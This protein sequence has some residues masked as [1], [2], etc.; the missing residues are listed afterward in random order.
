MP[1][2]K[3]APP[4]SLD[5][6][7]WV[8]GAYCL[9][10]GAMAFVAPHAWGRVMNA[11]LPQVRGAEGA[12]LMASG[13]ALI[14]AAADALRPALGTATHVLA[15]AVLCARAWEIRIVDNGFNLGIAANLVLG[16]GVALAPLA[17]RV[18][19]GSESARHDWLSMVAAALLIAGSVV[20]TPAHVPAEYRPFL[21]WYRA[22]FL[23]AGACLAAAEIRG[24][25]S[26]ALYRAAHL[27]AGATMVAWLVPSIWL[28][29]WVGFAFWFSLGL[30]V[31]LVPW[32]GP[33]LARRDKATLRSRLTLSMA[34]LS[35]IPLI[36]IATLFALRLEQSAAEQAFRLQESIALA[37]SH[38]VEDFVSLHEAAASGLAAEPGLLRLPPSQQQAMMDRVNR[39]FPQATTFSLG[40]AAGRNVAKSRGLPLLSYADQPQ[41]LNVRRTNQPYVTVVHG[42]LL[43]G[44]YIT[45]TVPIRDRD[46]KFEGIVQTGIETTRLANLVE[47]TAAR[48]G[49]EAYILDDAH[50]IVAHPDAS[51]VL[52]LAPI[53]N[54]PP[55]D[56]SLRYAGPTGEHLASAA[57]IPRLGWTVVIDRPEEIALAE[58]W[59]Q[60][61]V[62]LTGLLAGIL[63]AYLMATLVA[64]KLTGPL[65]SLASATARLANGDVS[66][67]LVKAGISEIDE[68]SDTFDRTRRLLAERTQE[69]D[70]AET[71]LRQINEELEARVQ[72]RSAELREEIAHRKEA[73]Q[74]T[75]EAYDTLSAVIRSSPLPILRFDSKGIISAWNPAAERVFGWSEQEALGRFNPI[76]AE[77]Q[78][79][80]YLDL[81]ERARNG[82]LIAGYEVRR[83]T[84]DR[85]PIE[86]SLSLASMRDRAGA[87]SGVLAIL[88][89][90][91][92]RKQAEEALRRQAALLDL[93]Y[94]AIIVRTE[95]DRIA[96]WNQGAQETYGWT[97]REAIGQVT[98]DLL[99]TRFPK[100]LAEIATEL[101]EK[102]RWEG[103]LVHAHKDGREITVASRWAAQ[104]NP[105]GRQ[106]GV[107]EINRDI[108][109]RKQAEARLR[110]AQKLE[111]LGLLAGGVAHDFNN[112]LVGVIGNAS[113]A[114]E[115]LPADNLAVELLEGVVKSGQQAAHLTRQMLAYSGKGKFMVEPLDLSA[116]IP[117]MSGLVQPSLPKKVALRFDLDPDLPAIEA[118]RGQVQQVF[119]NLVLNAGE[120]VGSHDGLI[121]VRTYVERVDEPYL[122]L[123]PE[124]AA[125]RPGKYVCLEVRDTGCGMDDATKARIFDPFFTTKF[126]GRGLGLAAVSGI[127]RGHKGAITVR[128]APG[129]GSCF[130]VLFP[131][132][133]QAVRTSA[134]ETRNGALHGSGVVLVVDDERVV[135]EMAKTALGREGYT[136]LLADSGPAAIDVLRGHPGEIALVVLDMSMPRMS[137]E[138]ALWELRKIRPEVKV[139]VSSGYSEAEAMTLF[140][141]QRVSGFIQK[142]YTFRELAEKVKITVG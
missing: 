9:L 107:L 36:A 79:Q 73:E 110:E 44:S 109:E 74:R 128:S 135:R 60:Q 21:F 101:A 85:G 121:S 37:I 69:R 1:S 116:L 17:A 81:I 62:T 50:R 7:Q 51:R 64:G 71:G 99:K 118:D 56:G 27:L 130:T 103:E 47:R 105:G 10:A 138:E 123:H 72:A 29:H 83:Q 102:G 66:A 11:S 98:H 113:L 48:V 136:V 134:A 40:D 65:Q 25:A 131:A 8:A 38:D 23:A 22:A 100:P 140:R 33:P 112:L 108:T 120:A 55:T 94:D 35:A 77:D 26:Q 124:A 127:V 92:E 68:L 61:N 125:L 5:A 96:F 39:A 31:A 139:I 106:I 12:L 97:P 89:D 126:T 95:E 6:L 87:V 91:T 70:R 115:M 104:R 42:R 32:L 19:R 137:G 90:I 49:G 54:V 46:G 52:S 53:S 142:P 111:S 13:F 76:I 57:Q 141:G 59:A 132:T 67:P 75:R 80:D 3:P 24:A 117:E 20:A 86:V 82:E 16:C 114:Q 122:R 18:W 129:S 58:L 15:G 88:T 78:V 84:K 14:A 43:P 4:L 2:T 30:A 41:F 34:A 45:L 93:A 133:E 63:A 28:Q 119:M